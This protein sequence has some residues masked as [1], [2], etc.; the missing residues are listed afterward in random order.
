MDF[1]I[2]KRLKYMFLL[3]FFFVFLFFGGK[4]GSERTPFVKDA[5]ALLILEKT[6]KRRYLY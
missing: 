2:N 1:L 5:L 6:E 3:V 4:H